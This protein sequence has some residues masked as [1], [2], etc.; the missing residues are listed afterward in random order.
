MLVIQSDK[1]K[2]KNLAVFFV[3]L[4]GAVLINFCCDSAEVNFECKEK[5]QGNSSS[6]LQPAAR[7]MH[8]T[9]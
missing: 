7:E 2:V 3:F 9:V 6:M 4:L 8:I 5:F 1:K